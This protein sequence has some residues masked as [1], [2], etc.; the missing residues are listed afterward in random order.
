MGFVVWDIM[1][2][3]LIAAAFLP[4]AV[5]AQDLTGTWVVEDVPFAPWTMV[6]AQEGNTVRGTVNQGSRDEATRTTYVVSPPVPIYAGV[7]DGASVEFKCQSPDEAGR[8]ISFKGEMHGNEI[9]FTR[10]VQVPP[11]RTPGRNGIFGAT[12]PSAFTARREGESNRQARA[13]LEQATQ[14]ASRASSTR[15]EASVAAQL[16]GTGMHSSVEGTIK[17][18]RKNPNLSRAEVSMG[19]IATT[20]V[21]H[22]KDQWTY[23]STA[24]QYSKTPAP[25]DCLSQYD[26]ARVASALHS[27]EM[28]GRD[29]VTIGG[30]SVE[31]QLVR[32]TTRGGSGVPTTLLPNQAGLSGLRAQTEATT[33]LCI[34]SML[35]ILRHQVETT[36]FPNLTMKAV[37]TFTT[38]ELGAEFSN[39]LFTFNPPA[40]AKTFGALTLGAGPAQASQAPLPQAPT[41]GSPTAAQSVQVP[42]AYRIGNGVSPPVLIESGQPTYT[43]EARRAHIEGTVMVSMVVMEDGTPSAIRVTRSLEPGLDQKAVEAVSKWRFRPGLKDDKPVPVMAS[44]QVN[45]HLLANPAD[46]Q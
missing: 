15:L 20:V 44:V 4:I 2:T 34:D 25:A 3:F 39:D 33:T 36:A 12:G 22:G 45:F 29:S 11:G 28:A 35:R 17:A 30:M 31:C 32:G 37:L 10:Q 21:C 7:R 43:E 14:A 46:P 13:L 16:D 9:A 40:D 27:P 26:P 24:N 42:G 23:L 6:L 5:W 41:Q 18:W 19:P 1:R 38:V 8:E